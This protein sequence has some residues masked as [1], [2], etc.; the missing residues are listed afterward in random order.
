[1]M[2]KVSATGMRRFWRNDRQIPVSGA[3]RTFRKT[4]VE[5]EGANG[6]G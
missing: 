2:S 6:Y 1:M 3:R 5:K 4:I